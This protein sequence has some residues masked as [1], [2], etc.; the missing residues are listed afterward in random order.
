MTF[1]TGK[2]AA[3]LINQYD[4]SPF[5]NN[6]DPSQSVDSHE[7]T[8]YQPGVAGPAKS[9]IVGL[10]DGVVSVS[11]FS[12]YGAAG[13]DAILSGTLQAATNPVLTV[14]PNGFTV[15]N[16]VKM[17]EAIATQLSQGIPVGGIIT[18][19]YNTQAT[20]GIDNGVW[21]HALEAETGT[22]NGASV[23][24]GAASTNGYSAHLHVTVDDASS[25][26]IK[27]Q[28]APDDATWADLVSF[29]AVSGVGYQRK[30]GTGTVDQ[31]VRYIISAFTGTSLT[32]AVAF[33]RR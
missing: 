10:R 7:S 1:L 22:E 21:L 31:Y 6:T 2:S 28:H 24:N 11:G 17:L 14:S 3:V 25:V 8:T 19:A 30:T 23:N 12:D 29:D 20:G 15:G 26:T 33:A 16:R 9:Y 4:L 27:V 13:S 5:V 18:F 32:F